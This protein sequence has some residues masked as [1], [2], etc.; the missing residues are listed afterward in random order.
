MRRS[1]SASVEGFA[2]LDRKLAMVEAAPSPHRKAAA[3]R[4]GARVI[5]DEER[6]LV[7]VRSGRLRRSIVEIP[8]ATNLPRSTDTIYIGPTLKDGWYGYMVEVGLGYGG[9]HPFVRPAIDMR[10]E[11]ALGLVLSFLG[12]D[13]VRAAQG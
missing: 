13:I 4:A 7:P 2:E 5:G 11:E 6:R 8:D 3:L 12:A 9:A 10:G 1:P